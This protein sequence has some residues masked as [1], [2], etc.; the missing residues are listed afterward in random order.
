MRRPTIADI[1]QRAGVTKAAVSFALN[2][3]PGVSAATRARVLAIA[4]EI[5]YQ[6]S[7]AARALTA[8]KAGAF[9][10]VTG[11]PAGGLGIEP[12]LL[13]LVA[14]IQAE[15]ARDQ[16][17]L[18]F[19]MADDTE[20][21]TGLYR[22]WWA[23]GRVDGVFVTG[24]RLDDRRLPVIGELRLP[25]VVIGPPAGAGPLPA[26]W[27]DERA[28]AAVVAAHLAGQGYRRVARL[29]GAAGYWDSQ[30]RRE[31]FDAAAAAAGLTSFSVTAGSSVEQ[32]AQAAAGVLSVAEAPVA[33]F[34]DTGILAVAALGAAQ[35]LGLRVPGD[36]AIVSGQD[37]AACEL[38]HPPLTALRADA[39][40]VG[41]AAARMLTELAAGG[42]P[43]SLVAGEP[44]LQVRASTGPASTRIASPRRTA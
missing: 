36:V 8:G 40:V 44:A 16:V 25:A 15:L 7:S 14:G 26:L 37:S 41:A 29:G 35:R 9:G 39:A 3:Q 22:Q 38:T 1:A 42:H 2:G 27:P 12:S 18:L 33:V 5:G 23:Q 20:A 34:C 31:A 28:A 24:L 4:G 11:R 17:S 43:G 10:L 30:L 32:A 19:T 6:P 13:Q 21:E